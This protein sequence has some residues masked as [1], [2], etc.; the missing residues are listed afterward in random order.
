MCEPQEPAIELKDQMTPS[1]QLRRA[2]LLLTGT[3]PEPSAYEELLQAPDPAQTQAILERHI[4][5][6]MDSDAFYRRLVDFGHD[7]ITVGRY[8]T[9][10]SGEA[11]WGHMSG[12]LRPCPTDSPHAGALYLQPE[13]GFKSGDQPGN[14]DNP[15]G[16]CYDS[17]PDGSGVAYPANEVEIEPWWAPGTTVKV[18]GRA[19]SGVRKHPAKD[20]SG[21]Y[22]CGRFGSIYFTPTL[23]DDAQELTDPV[24]SCGPNLVYCQTYS[25]FGGNNS[26]DE[27]S[28]RRHASEE[29]ARLFAHLV[30]HNRPLHHL[31]T[32]NY[33]VGTNA[34][35]HL[36]VRWARQDPAN[37]ALDDLTW[38]KND[39]TVPSD[40]EHDPKD[41]LA[42]REFVVESLNPNLLSGST[43]PNGDLSRTASWDPADPSKGLATAGVLT[44]MGSM[45][46]F[47]RER[48][49]AARFIEIFTCRDFN[50]PPADVHF[51]PYD[52]DPATTGTCQHCHQLMDPASIAFKR[53]DFRGDYIWQLPVLGGGYAAQITADVNKKSS[54]YRRWFDAWS[55]DTV[56]TPFSQAQLDENP[57]RLL[58]D[59]IPNDVTLFGVNNDGTSGPLGFGK[60]V[61][62][63]GEFDRCAVRQL[64]RFAV[65]RD[66]DPSKERGY[67][68]KLVEEF[69]A[70]ERHAKPFIKQLMLGQTFKRGL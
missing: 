3:T 13:G 26:L 11:Y 14:K 51:A 37:Q 25:G 62:K 38:W 41:P 50:P 66:I 56:L 68:D 48:V 58:M 32:A 69:V 1:R 39:T 40:P 49:R 59:T 17:A 36:Y 43:A 44:M 64:H 35:R 29:P 46:S 9:G 60:M 61:V 24:C 7:W 22:V 20:G 18:V 8:T 5:E 19:G 23:A 34:L 45:S 10:A 12:V 54:P 28:Q 52:R 63:S 15:K 6:L 30:W 33:S 42:W 53:W 27:N 55:A 4:D 16:I 2:W 21:D 65:G 67:L 70:G 31:L 47:S 57:H